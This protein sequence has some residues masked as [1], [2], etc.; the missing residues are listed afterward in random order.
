MLNVRSVFC[1]QF[2]I[3]LFSITMNYVEID[4]CLLAYLSN[5][6][7][8]LQFLPLD[9]HSKLHLDQSVSVV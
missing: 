3:F 7:T 2:A 1:S 6:F 8:V 9:I 5:V 4:S